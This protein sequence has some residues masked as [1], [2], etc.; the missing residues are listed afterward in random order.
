MK[1]FVSNKLR[2]DWLFLATGQLSTNQNGQNFAHKFSA[3]S[4]PCIYDRNFLYPSMA[5]PTFLVCFTSNLFIGH[6]EKKIVLLHHPWLITEVF[7]D[8]IFRSNVGG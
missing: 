1:I 2:S 6:T 8:A 7:D 3:V 5:L 4:D